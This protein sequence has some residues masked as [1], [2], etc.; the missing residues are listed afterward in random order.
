MLFRSWSDDERNFN[1]YLDS[2]PVDWIMPVDFFA[3]QGVGDAFALR[4][5]LP[6]ILPQYEKGGFERRLFARKDL[7]PIF[8]D[9]R[10]R[11]DIFLTDDK[12]E[13]FHVTDHWNIYHH[14]SSNKIKGIDKAYEDYYN[15][16]RLK[17]D[18]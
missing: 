3:H 2:L 14:M 1:R 6:N 9:L 15:I 8:E 17:K 12:A 13:L 18:N 11:F 10:D 5:A 7:L 4:K 16:A